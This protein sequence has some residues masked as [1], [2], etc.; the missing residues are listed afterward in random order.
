[1]K[2]SELTSKAKEVFGRVFN[3]R[4]YVKALLWFGRRRIDLLFHLPRWVR[5]TNAER[6]DLEAY[7]EELVFDHLSDETKIQLRKLAY[8][9][10]LV[11]KPEP[12]TREATLVEAM[13]IKNFGNDPILDKT[14]V[15]APDAG[16]VRLDSA[17]AA[18]DQNGN[19]WVPVSAALPPPI[20]K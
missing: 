19:L 13:E 4:N 10:G 5:L 3:R 11:P 12:I 14:I 20:V 16:T 7:R 2:L 15:T 9:A 8:G 17:V 1:M 18:R 6:S